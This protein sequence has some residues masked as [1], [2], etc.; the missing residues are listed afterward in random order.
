MPVAIQVIHLFGAGVANHKTVALGTGRQHCNIHL[1]N[2]QTASGVPD[3][4]PVEVVGGIILNRDVVRVQRPEVVEVL[5]DVGVVGRVHFPLALGVL[6]HL[7]TDDLQSV[8]INI[9]PVLGRVNLFVRKCKARVHESVVGIPDGLDKY[10]GILGQIYFLGILGVVRPVFMNNLERHVERRVVKRRLGIIVGKL[11][12]IHNAGTGIS[13]PVFTIVESLPVREVVIQIIC[14]VGRLLN[15]TSE[16]FA[17][18]LV[19]EVRSGN[20]DIL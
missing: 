16:H 5:G 18:S 19:A 15:G 8:H 10:G 1:E 7:G 6:V 11:A 4:S 20:L 3:N 13:K 2:V 17:G 12:C 14:T 9:A